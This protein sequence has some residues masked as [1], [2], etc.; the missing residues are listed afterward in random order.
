MIPQMVS[1]RDPIAA[2]MAPSC[3]Q[4]NAP[5]HRVQTRVL[6]GG[7]VWVER[8][9]GDECSNGHVAITREGQ[10]KVRRLKAADEEIFGE[11]LPDAEPVAEVNTDF[12]VFPGP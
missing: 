8:V 1:S 11:R 2:R 6:V 4:C 9:P 7:K 12:R 3:P 5:T 10:S